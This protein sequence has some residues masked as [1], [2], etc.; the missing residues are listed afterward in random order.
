MSNIL[1]V[2][3]RKYNCDVFFDCDNTVLLLPTFFSLHLSKTGQGFAIHSYIDLNGLV[4][5]RF[6]LESLSETTRNIYTNRLNQFLNWL[7][8]YDRK[9]GTTLLATHNNLPAEFIN[10][11]YVDKHLCIVSVTA[12]TPS[13]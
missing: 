9:N 6:V 2:A 7:S 5:K 12:T 10:K 11:E 13:V 4:Q 8:K 3:S 1:Q